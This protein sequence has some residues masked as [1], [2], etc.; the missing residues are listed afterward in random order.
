METKNRGG[1]YDML[2]FQE[3]KSIAEK[4]M[5]TKATIQNKDKVGYR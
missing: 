3:Q 2:A 1:G 5:T 4:L